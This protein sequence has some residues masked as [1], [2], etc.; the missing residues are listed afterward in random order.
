MRE[1]TE[2]KSRC[3][4][5]DLKESEIVELK[6]SLSQID[7]IVETVAAMANASGGKNGGLQ[8]RILSM[9]AQVL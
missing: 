3:A 8:N 9:P 2:E 6:P 7:R 4:I 1:V 5:L